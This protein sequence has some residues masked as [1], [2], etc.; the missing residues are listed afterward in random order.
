V[1]FSFAQGEKIRFMDKETCYEIGSLMGNIHNLT[2]NKT[3]E[4]VS[5]NKQS[6]LESP[7]EHL[8]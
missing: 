3:I 1:L 2:L 5:Y 4:R 7:Y 8:K 6:L